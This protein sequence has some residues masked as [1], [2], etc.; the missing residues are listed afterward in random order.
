MRMLTCKQA[1]KMVMPYIDGRLDEEELE[2]FL[3]HVNECPACREELEIYF[4]VYV[5]LKAFPFHI[6]NKWSSAQ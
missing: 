3:S 5:G 4:T 6:D 2:D 1:E